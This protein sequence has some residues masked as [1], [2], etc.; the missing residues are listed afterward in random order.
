MGYSLI[1]PDAIGIEREAVAEAVE[2]QV[3][4]HFRML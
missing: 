3:I 1:Y 2:A 4:R